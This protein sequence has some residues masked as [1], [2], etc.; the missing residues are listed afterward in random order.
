MTAKMTTKS[1]ASPQS[2]SHSDN[3]NADHNPPSTELQAWQDEA[4]AQLSA[5]LQAIPFQDP[6]SH[7]RELLAKGPPPSV[8]WSANVQIVPQALSQ[9]LNAQYRHQTKPT[10]VLSFGTPEVFRSQGFLGDLVICWEWLNDQALQ[11]QHPVGTE[12][13]ILMVH[14]LL[15]LLGFDH[16]TPDPE[17]NQLMRLWETRLL[18]WVRQEFAHESTKEAPKS[19]DSDTP[20]LI[21][22]SVSE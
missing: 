20:G 11:F 18:R 7:W 16:E 15:H 14:G 10:D 3:A 8:P 12:L 19:D 9:A 5:W 22:R 17:A 13:Q 4:Q 1:Q 21:A 2:P 6:H